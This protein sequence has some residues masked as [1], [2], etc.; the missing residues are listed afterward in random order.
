MSTTGSVLLR[1]LRAYQVYG[2]NTD[3]GKTIF[4]TILCNA[5]ARRRPR[6]RVCYMKPIST[7][8]LREADYYH[9]SRFS[10]KTESQSMIQYERP[11]SPHIAASFDSVNDHSERKFISP[12]TKFNRRRSRRMCPYW[13]RFS[14]I[15]SNVRK[16]ALELCCSKRLAESI[17][18]HLLGILKQIS[19]DHSVCLCYW[20]QIIVWVGSHR[21]SRHLSRFIFEAMT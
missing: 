5:L 18:Q 4:S 13:K 21:Q 3:V 10:P 20:L 17:L 15:F 11:V 16:L 2:A 9:V 1:S 6:E 7:G 19:T 14:L 8:P 12:L